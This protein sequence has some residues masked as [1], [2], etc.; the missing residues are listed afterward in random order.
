M[1]KAKV[2]VLNVGLLSIEG[3][4]FAS[5]QHHGTPDAVLYAY[6]DDALTDY[7][8]W[9]GRESYAYGELGENLTLD[10]L[11]ESQ[12]SV[13]DVFKVG[14]V[15]CEATFPRIPCAKINFRLQHPLGQKTMIACGRSGIYFRILKPGVIRVTDAFERVQTAPVP[16]T[17]REIY[18]RMVGGVRVSDADRARV[19]ANGKV[20]MERIRR[21]FPAGG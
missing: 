5:P 11:D 7:F 10:T 1:L 12:V 20:P 15:L 16:F 18:D 2:D 14:E 13:G 3:D 6:G 21:W 19:L 17:I 9:L 4:E 8:A